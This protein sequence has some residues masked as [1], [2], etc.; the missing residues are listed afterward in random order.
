MYFKEN[1]VKNKID[2][3]YS[4][5]ERL[6]EKKLHVAYG[7]DDNFL[8]GAAISSTSLLIN[9]N[10]T[11]YLHIFTDSIDNEKTLR[12]KRMAERFHID[13]TIYHID[14][15]PLEKLPTKNWPYSAYYRLI[16]FDYLG[17]DIEKLLYLDADI[18]CKGS[19]NELHDLNLDSYT[20]AVVPDIEE[21]QPKAVERLNTPELN[22]VYFNSGVML[23]NLKNWNLK[24]LTYKVISFI[25]KNKNLKYPD[26]DAL[27]ILLINENYILP[28]KFNCIYSIK[29]ELKDKT[30]Q[31]YKEIINDESVFIHYVGTT[32]P[33]NEWGQY[34]STIYFTHAY[35][36]STWCDIPLIGA[37]TPLQWKKKS[38]HEFRKRKLI[39]S[40]ISRLNY[41]IKK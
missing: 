4:E 30:H 22:G 37:N 2:L 7:V 8:F 33:W 5:K 25:L 28:R 36:Q 40:I 17:K 24:K 13:I 12:F 16:A 9:N 15:K 19:I 41:L 1:I 21:M 35:N 23:V 31:D 6:E 3:H 11:I 20:C 39:S 38:K 10:I 18:I 27:N 29:S 14:N 32:K 34:P 26:Q